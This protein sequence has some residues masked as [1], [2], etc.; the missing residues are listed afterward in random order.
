MTDV[1]NAVIVH[2]DSAKAVVVHDDSTKSGVDSEAVQIEVTY[3]VDNP[4][5]DSNKQGGRD[6]LSPSARRFAITFNF[7]NVGVFLVGLIASAASQARY[8]G[9]VGVVGGPGAALALCVVC[10]LRP[11]YAN[12]AAEQPSRCGCCALTVATVL[13][14]LLEAFAF[15]VFALSDI[16]GH[17]IG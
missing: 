8:T 16:T 7:I 4:D 11:R 9:S 5:P 12:R 6:V 2:D 13:A 14:F 17:K 15:F 10:Y 1:E 3:L